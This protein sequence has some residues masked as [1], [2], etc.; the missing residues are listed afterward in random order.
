MKLYLGEI[1]APPLGYKIRPDFPYPEKEGNPHMK[2][3]HQNLLAAALLATMG[4]AAVAQTSVPTAPSAQ[5]RGPPDAAQMEQHRAR[6]HERMAQRFAELKAK[7]QISAAQESSWNAWVNGMKPPANRQRPDRATVAAMSTPE[8]ID[9][10]RN[11][12]AQRNTEMDARMDLTKSFYGQLSAAQ[13][14]VF[15]AESAKFMHGP[16]GGHGKGHHGPR[17]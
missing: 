7:L 5:R 14:K 13:Q 2:T 6:M 15:D 9:F 1:R 10:M 4:F 11:M 8:R 17:S 16:R 12:R 3:L